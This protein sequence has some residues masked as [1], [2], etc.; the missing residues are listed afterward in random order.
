MCYIFVK[1]GGKVLKKVSCLVII[2][3]FCLS[4]ILPVVNS[5]YVEK[6]IY[7][8]E[9]S[10]DYWDYG[11]SIQKTNDDVLP[12]EELWNKTF[13]GYG[14]GNYIRETSDGG[15]KIISNIL[16]S[17][18]RN[19]VIAF[20]KTD[21]DGNIES[22][23]VINLFEND[24]MAIDSIRETSDGGY[25][26]AG[27]NGGCVG[28]VLWFNGIFLLKTDEN[29]VEEWDFK[30]TPY[31]VIKTLNECP[32]GSII[33][34][35]M[36]FDYKGYDDTLL[37]K[38]SKHGVEQRIINIERNNDDLKCVY[39]TEDGGCLLGGYISKDTWILKLDKRGNK[40][41]ETIFEEGHEGAKEYAN[42]IYSASDG[43]YIIAV[44]SDSSY[45]R[46]IKIDNL[47][48][49]ISNES[50]D[51]G[52]I[53]SIQKT[54]DD[55]FIVFSKKSK[56]VSLIKFNSTGSDE[57]LG[58][59]IYNGVGIR[60]KIIRKTIDDGFILVINTRNM[61]SYNNPYEGFWLI[62]IDRLGNKIWE[63]YLDMSN[64]WEFVTC[65]EIDETSDGGYIICGSHD[66][67]GDFIDSSLWL[68]KFGENNP[69]SI[70]AVEGINE[71]IIN[72]NYTFYASS[73][74]SEDDKISYFFDW[75]DGTNSS[76]TRYDLS[77]N[78]INVT[79]NWTNEGTYNVKVRAKDEHG[80]ESDWAILEVSM[81]KTKAVAITLFLEIF[82]QRFPFFE[83]ILNQ[84]I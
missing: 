65:R 81:P 69:P 70:P 20:I 42:Y 22:K 33:L 78:I 49:E 14:K 23:K 4:S 45:F 82:F 63:N 18:Y 44:A 6:S 84:I 71:G 15:Y 54:D 25:L 27:I 52:S 2:L 35:C 36:T 80:Y 79:H 47:G 10:L 50:F 75:D 61:S 11:Y 31:V 37:I 67:L 64:K 17:I 34:G 43:G 24:D 62:K 9:T 58:S 59:F 83:K 1:S 38:L 19:L 66:Y 8:L 73:T 32:D 48:V 12:P 16:D 55:G 60:S 3:L 21:K 40:E 76:W 5:I 26:F 30:Y 28:D 56:E 53:F 68:I 77:G 51:Y 39:P 41:W 29:G 72:E 74:D 7:G 57:Y 46:I 13:E